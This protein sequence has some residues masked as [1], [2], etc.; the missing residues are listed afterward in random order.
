MKIYTSILNTLDLLSKTLKVVQ[1]RD[2]YKFIQLIILLII[3]SILD[4]LTLVSVIPLVYIL[5][6]KENLNDY[7]SSNLNKL[8][9]TNLNLDANS[10]LILIPILVILVMLIATISRL[11][12]VFKTNKFIEDIR[13]SISSKLINNYINGNF[14]E[15]ETGEVAKLILSEVDQFIIIVFQPTILMLTNIFLLFG[16]LIYIFNVNI[17]ASLLS[18]F[19]LCVFYIAFYIFSKRILNI[20]GLKSEKANKGRFKIGIESFESIKDIKIYSAENYFKKKFKNYSKSF[21]MTNAIYNSLVASPKYILEMIVFM[22]LSFSILI[23][24]SRDLI[25]LNS[26]PLLATFS[27]SAYKAQPA[28]SNIIYGINSLEYGS[29]IINNLNSE[30]KFKDKKYLDSKK[31]IKV[32]NIKNKNISLKIKNLSFNY[33]NNEVIKNINLEIYNPSLFI[34]FG[35]SGSGKSTLLNLISGLQKPQ[36]GQIVFNSKIFK[37]REPRISYLHQDFSL[38]DASIA[39]N[40]AFGIKKNNIDYE[41]LKSSLIKAEIFN[42]V[43]NLK[44][45]VFERIGEKGTSLSVGQ[46]QR[47]ALARAL[48][49]KPDVLLLD[50]PTSA[51]DYENEQKIISTLLKISENISVLMSTHKIDKLPKHLRLGFINQ[52]NNLELKK[53]SDFI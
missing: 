47:I 6:G 22:I 11:F 21:A 51:L 2:K 40:V 49:F 18:L 43:S 23:I 19:V 34:L 38:I 20:E 46:R 35:E 37:D 27:F 42:Y 1:L 29:K 15:K 8:N 17:S 32:E 10:L 52:S 5:E 39:E 33:A 13:Y 3:Q 50:E 12:I 31:E 24:A 26:I 7:I 4:V 48:Y 36:K 53:V 25:N 9:I 45:S 16:I 41:N 44:N 30:I 28:L 14:N